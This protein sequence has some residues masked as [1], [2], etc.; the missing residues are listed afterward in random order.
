MKKKG[1]II[2]HSN[3]TGT[4]PA[5]VD[6]S[7]K[8]EKCCRKSWGSYEEIKRAMAMEYKSLRIGCNIQENMFQIFKFN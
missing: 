6:L 1:K 4:F 7:S 2:F 5:I 3:E 8:V